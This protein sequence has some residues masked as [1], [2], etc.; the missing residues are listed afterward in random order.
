[1]TSRASGSCSANLLNRH[2]RLKGVYRALIVLPWAIPQIVSLAV[3]RTELNAEF[4]N[5]L[6][7]TLT[8]NPTDVGALVSGIE[9]VPVHEGWRWA[10]SA[11]LLG[12]LALASAPALRRRLSG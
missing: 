6:S 10:A 8:V 7:W 1:M 4:G 5:D 12:L 3:W 9:P 11:L 2:L